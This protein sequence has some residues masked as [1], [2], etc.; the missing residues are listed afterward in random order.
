MTLSL[1]IRLASLPQHAPLWNWCAVT[2]LLGNLMTKQ[3]LRKEEMPQDK[4]EDGDNKQLAYKRLLRKKIH[5]IV[6]CT[7]LVKKKR[8]A[9]MMAQ[10]RLSIPNSLWKNMTLATL[11]SEVTVCTVSWLMIWMASSILW[12]LSFSASSNL[13]LATNST[14]YSLT[15][16]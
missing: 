15:L 4:G 10:S 14:K 7:S 1:Q 9:K 2:L 3:L 11:K 13:N 6:K 16:S 8:K 5:S 12:S